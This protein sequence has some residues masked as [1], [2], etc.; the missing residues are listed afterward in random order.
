[1]S[2][3]NEKAKNEIPTKLLPH[4]LCVDSSLFEDRKDGFSSYKIKPEDIIIARRNEL[5]KNLNYRQLLPNAIF[6]NNGKMWA[7]ERTEKGGEPT[8][9]KQVS[10]CVGGH[11]DITDLAYRDDILDSSGEPIPGIIDLEASLEIALGRE[12]EEEVNINANIIKSYDLDTVI[13]AD[14]TPTDQKHVALVRIVELESNDGDAPLVESSEDEL[15]SYGFIEPKELL[16]RHDDGEIELETWAIIAC[17]M[18]IA[19]QEK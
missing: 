9:H 3:Q 4:I 16:R 19:S 6:I 11:W 7:Y 15:L 13:A 12:L 5:E 8:L 17:K 1:M 18:F 2:Q 14:I 10:V